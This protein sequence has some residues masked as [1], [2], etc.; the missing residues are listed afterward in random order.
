V[1][2][3]PHP[4]HTVLLERQPPAD[5]NNQPC[6]FGHCEIDPRCIGCKYKEK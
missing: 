2:V 1:I 6:V 4:C 3:K 5:K